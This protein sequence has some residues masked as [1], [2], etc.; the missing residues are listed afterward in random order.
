MTIHNSLRAELTAL[1][2]FVG[3]LEQEQKVLLANDTD[4]LLQLAE[5]KSGSALLLNQLVEKRTRSFLEILPDLKTA[6]I[7]KWLKQN[8]SAAL[9][10]WQEINTLADRAL[11]INASSGELIQLKMQHNQHALAVLSK[12]NDTANLYGPNG[13]RNLPSSSGK[14]I[15]S[16]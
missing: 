8:E 14:P 4:A 16:V 10:L 6:T 3:L 15:A 1:R 7:L 9:P 13:Q 5:Q 11:K 2:S 12:S